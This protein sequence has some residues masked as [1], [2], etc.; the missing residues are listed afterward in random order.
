MAMDYKELQALQAKMSAAQVQQLEIAC[1]KELGARLLRDV[2]KNTPVGIYPAD[3]GK[4]GG[5]LRRNWKV[6]SPRLKNGGCVLD[7]INP[8]EYAS[9]VEYGHRQEPGRYVP[10][11]GKRLKA[12]WVDG[13]F[14]LTRAESRL[15][16]QAQ[17]IV[18]A[19]VQ[20]YMEDL[21]NGK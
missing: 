4:Q 2:V 19:K 9:Y 11:L 17:A 16:R 1:A 8:T 20:K 15:Q 21:L 12:S 5:T 7:V 13:R 10:A 3:S 14:M 6:T 18:D